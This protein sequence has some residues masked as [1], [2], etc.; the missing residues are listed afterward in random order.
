[1]WWVNEWDDEELSDPTH[2][3]D[4]L[5]FRVFVLYPY[6]VKKLVSSTRSLARHLE[7]KNGKW[8]V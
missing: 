2:V 5:F 4:W 7:E 1:M 6:N 3:I 8:G